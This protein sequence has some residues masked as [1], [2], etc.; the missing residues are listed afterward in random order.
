MTAPEHSAKA[1]DDRAGENREAP[2]P[3]VSGPP[4]QTL[5]KRRDFLSA[6]RARKSAA[7][8]LVLQGRRR[9]EAE[10]NARTP[11]EAMRVGFTA[12]KKVGGAVVRNR[13]KRRL[14][15]AARAVLPEAGRPG[16]DY[17]LIARADATVARPFENLLDDLRMAVSRVHSDKTRGGE[18]LGEKR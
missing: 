12:S 1:P 13:A 5:L 11:A 6:A 4:L 9:R 8:A 3:L 10:A 7:P 18:R 15:E 16:W 14:R 17:V 2:A